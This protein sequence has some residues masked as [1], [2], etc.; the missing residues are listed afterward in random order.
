MDRTGEVMVVEF[1]DGE[2]IVHRG[3]ELPYKAITNNSYSNSLKYLQNFTGYGGDQIITNRAGSQERF[4]RAVSGIDNLSEYCP[5][6]AFDILDSVRRPDT[7]WQIIYDAVSMQ[8][9]FKLNGNSE[10]SISF[11]DLDFEGSERV[12]YFYSDLPMKEELDFVSYDP[13]KD[14][15]FGVEYVEKLAAAQ[16]ISAELAEKIKFR[17]KNRKR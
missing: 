10:K 5:G 17:L 6:A 7:Q 16:D 12:A 1:L 11:Q 9:F 8:I 15:R 3:E 4:V 2:I 13:E 14:Y